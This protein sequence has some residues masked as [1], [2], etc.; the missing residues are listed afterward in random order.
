MWHNNITAH[1]QT[2][3]NRVCYFRFFGVFLASK[4][5]SFR[6]YFIF[7]A[8]GVVRYDRR[9]TCGT[10]TLLHMNRLNK[11][12]SAIIAS[13]MCSL[14]PKDLHSELILFRILYLPQITTLSLEVL[15][16]NSLTLFILYFSPIGQEY[17]FL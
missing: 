16:T 5:S 13:L 8:A 11:T 7:T 12:E 14:L 3:Q 2:Q 6:T 4:E 17:P 1:E 15:G 10:I 9:K